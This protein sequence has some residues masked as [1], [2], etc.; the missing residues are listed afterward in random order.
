MERP[1]S[2]CRL[3]T[4]RWQAIVVASALSVPSA[5]LGRPVAPA[6]QILAGLESTFYLSGVPRASQTLSSEMRRYRV[7]AASIAVIDDYRIVWL[8]A[9][10]F[11]NPSS[12][13]PATT[14]TLF[15]AASMS[16]PVA[17]AAIL[18]LF[19]ARSL[20]L[21]ADV[22]TLLR[23]WKLPTPADGWPQRV[24][25]RRLL[26]HTAGIN[27][28]GFLGY[29]RDAPLP[30][31]TQV[32]DGVPPANNPPIRVTGV[33]GSTM[34]YSGGGTSIAQQVAVDESGETFP[35]FMQQTLLAPLGMTHS[36]F[37]QPLPSGLG[38]RAADGYYAD[39]KPVHRGWHVYPTMAAAGLWSTPSDLAAFVV[40]IQNALRGRGRA[41]ID[42]TVAR[43]MTTKASDG[44]GLGPGVSPGYFSHN[45]ANE[46][47]QGIFIGL[48][49]GGKGVVV[50]TNSDNG[51]LLADELVHSVAKA[52]HWPVLQPVPKTTITLAGAQLREFAG[53]Y[54][55]KLGGDTVVLN[56]TLERR[57]GHG[58]LILRSTLNSFPLEIYPETPTRFFTLTGAAFT[59]APRG[60]TVNTVDFAGTKFR[61]IHPSTPL[62]ATRS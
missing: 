58:V 32:L 61:R 3:V 48:D 8:Y 37:D 17:A 2:G 16:K 44:F 34:E 30:T 27:V 40:A 43:E 15:Q 24:T 45:G 19:E 59:F 25:M 52:Y 51:L 6:A 49:R 29:D 1:R 41:P 4:W 12:R 38:T 60:G 47:F 26:S 7:A 53:E 13:V 22:N 10:G 14:A 42:T 50:M 54:E 33:P 56:I 35:A 55:A 9:A 23:S 21:D 31:L 18:R 20:S 62:G 57:A 39:G 11:A 28:H 5:A 46:G 36:T